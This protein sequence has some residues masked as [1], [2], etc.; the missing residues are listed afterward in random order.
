[1]DS[2]P[3]VKHSDQSGR[4]PV[5]V[6]PVQLSF[7]QEDETVASYFRDDEPIRSDTALHCKF[8]RQRMS[9]QVPDTLPHTAN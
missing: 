7:V 4:A 2:V 6:A 8:D 1:M 3:S 5:R 9:R